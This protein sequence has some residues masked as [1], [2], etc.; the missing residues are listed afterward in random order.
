MFLY[1]NSEQCEKNI[2]KIPFITALKRIKHQ[3]TNLT[4]KVKDI[5]S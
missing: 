5:Y 4:K 1:I 2:K 3:G